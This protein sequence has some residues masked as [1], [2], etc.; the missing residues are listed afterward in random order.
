MMRTKAFAAFGV[1]AMLAAAGC[2]G[3]RA[4][5]APQTASP[6]SP[7]AAV[8][9]DWTQRFDSKPAD[10][11]QG[12]TLLR[13]TPLA[14]DV[15][16]TESIGPRG[17]VLDIPA[18]GLH[19]VVP[20]GALKRETAI[21]AT[22]LAG[23][24]VAYEFGPHGTHFAL[25]LVVTQATAGTNADSLPAGTV[26]QLGY[27]NGPD[28]LDRVKKQ[29]RVAEI[30]SR[31]AVVTDDAVVFPVWHFSGYTVVWGLHRDDDR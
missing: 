26:L 4:P 11:G 28:A 29:A 2:T 3:D 15:S 12:T 31:L 30:I 27:F 22:A 5:L 14:A 6:A 23:D 25:P 16:V 10:I 7:A 19:V 20:P 1:L 17:G 18:A 24:M 8:S 13:R 9:L 21:T